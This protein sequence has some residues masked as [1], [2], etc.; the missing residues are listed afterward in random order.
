MVRR[1]PRS[2]R[3]DTL[4]HSTTLVRSRLG[5]SKAIL[6]P[7]FGALNPAVTLVIDV[8]PAQLSTGRAGNPDLL[9]QKSDSFDATI[10]KYWNGGFVAVAGYYRKITNRVISAGAQE[11]IDGITYIVTRPRN[12]GRAKLQGIE[13]SGQNFFDFL[14]GA[15][16]GIGVMGSFTY[17]DSEV[18][19]DDSL[20]G[21][22]LDRKST[23]L[24]SSH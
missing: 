21:E 9:P 5:C 8:N 4:F 19:G 24:N 20:A 14:P 2:K 12:V 6:R 7:E 22:P 11:E 18:Q 17:A 3:K 13:V 23:R 15:L 10:E 1:Q 16:N